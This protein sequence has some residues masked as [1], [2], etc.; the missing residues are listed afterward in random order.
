L[1]DIV[2]I[3]DVV[4]LMN[5]ELYQKLALIGLSIGIGVGFSFSMIGYTVGLLMDLFKKI[6]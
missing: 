4:D 1:T 2:E 6:F 3:V 5:V